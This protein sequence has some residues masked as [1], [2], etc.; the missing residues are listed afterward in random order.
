MLQY[1]S[2]SLAAVAESVRP[3]LQEHWDEAEAPMHGQQEYVLD[4]QQY[5]LFEEL[6]MLHIC[7]ARDASMAVRGYAVFT[8]TPCYHKGGELMASLDALYLQPAMRRGLAAL[9]LLRAAEEALRKR[10]VRSVQY[11][12]P[13]ARPCHALYRRLGAK[14]TESVFHKV[15]A[16]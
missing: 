3:L 10:G 5:T 9:Q 7:T 14:H 13:V 8:L 6:N 2:E 16:Q 1:Q 12:S 11:S 4:V 15:L